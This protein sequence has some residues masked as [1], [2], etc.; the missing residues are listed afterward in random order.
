MIDV[1]IVFGFIFLVTIA[2]LF[3]MAMKGAYKNGWSD[4][5]AQ[6]NEE[7]RIVLEEYNEIASRPAAGAHELL[8]RMRDEKADT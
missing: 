3:Y 6:L 4:K 8:R 7:T 2:G 5:E 1:F